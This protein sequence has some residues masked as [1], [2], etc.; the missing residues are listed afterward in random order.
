MLQRFQVEPVNVRDFSKD[1]YI[2]QR[3]P[4]KPTHVIELS[5]NP[6]N[7]TELL[8]LLAAPEGI[9]RLSTEFNRIH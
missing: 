5:E 8:E 3:F 2:L 1:L 6:T 4:K 7:V 9:L